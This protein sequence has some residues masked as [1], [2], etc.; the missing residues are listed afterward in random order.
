[1][2]KYVMVIVGFLVMLYVFGNA[3]IAIRR[4][5]EF[6]KKGWRGLRPGSP[7]DDLRF[8]GV[9]LIIIGAVWAWFSFGLLLKILH[10]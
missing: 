10:E 9:I 7:H 3:I 1:M 8:M 5:A 4:P 6:L 2:L